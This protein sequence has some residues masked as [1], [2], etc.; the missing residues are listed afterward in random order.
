MGGDHA[1][2]F[3]ELGLGVM[4]H[5]GLA[6]F[7]GTTPWRYEPADHPPTE[8]RPEALDPEQW[9]IAVRSAGARYICLTA[10]HHD[11]FALWH[12]DTTDYGVASSPCPRDMVGE[13]AEAARTHGLAFVCY[14]SWYDKS[15]P[16]GHV[17]DRTDRTCDA[18]YLAYAKRQL[19]ELLTAY[20]PVEAVWLDIAPRDDAQLAA[21]RNHI[22]EIQPEALF[23][24]NLHTDNDLADIREFEAPDIDMI[25]AEYRGKPAEVAYRVPPADGADW[26]WWQFA[27][28]GYPLMTADDVARLFAYVRG[29]GATLTLNTSPG[30][31]GQLPEATVSFLADVGAHLSE[32]DPPIGTAGAAEQ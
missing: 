29:A 21:V 14:F 5:F 16:G 6:T 19:S 9:V 22:K 32:R 28:T 4:M 30:P 17:V 10:K 11:G 3:V 1:R 15:H 7:V 31:S 2:E 18:D 23:I 26:G 13:L 8:Y 27:D 12:T 20:G 24:P 25:P